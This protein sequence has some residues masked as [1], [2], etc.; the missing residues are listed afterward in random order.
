MV[1]A[2]LAA[3]ARGIMLTSVT[4]LLLLP[5]LA[6]ADGPW[7]GLG[8]VT[9]RGPKYIQTWD[10]AKSTVC[11]ALPS[12]IPV[13]IHLLLPHATAAAPAALRPLHL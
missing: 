13:P 4:T 11:G 6:T 9:P 1:V 8:K 2:A 3:A 7:W 12:W 5:S 10:M